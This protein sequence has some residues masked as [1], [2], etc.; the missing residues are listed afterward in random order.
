MKIPMEL[1]QKA[2]TGSMKEIWD[3]FIV[4]DGE[5]EEWEKDYNSARDGKSIEFRIW[6]LWDGS[7]RII[8][9]PK[10]SKVYIAGIP[11]SEDEYEEEKINRRKIMVEAILNNIENKSVIEPRGKK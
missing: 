10:E 8:L 3:T 6:W 4:L 9:K 5:Y 11:F 7:N 1:A 2:V